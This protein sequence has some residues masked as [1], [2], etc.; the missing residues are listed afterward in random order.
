MEPIFRTTGTLDWITIL[1]FSSLLFIIIA[2]SLF[3]TRFL[4]YIILP[5][6]NKYIYMYNKKEK[7]MNW[8]NVFF[9]LFQIINFSLFIFFAWSIISQPHPDHQIFGYFV[10]LGT[11]I[12]FQIIKFIF[13]IGNGFIFSN[14]KTFSELVFKKISYLN[15]S[16]ILMFIAN[17][18]LCY[19]LKESKTVVYITVIL[20]L[21]ING[22]GWVTVLKNHQKFITN[23]FF[24]F[25]LY[26][27][28]L[29]IA[30]FVIMGS[31]L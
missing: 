9:T 24:Y 12:L 5:F 1:L 29:E 7:L 14:I 13:Q 28:A 2:K 31:L 25:I 18:I 26:L 6:N 19:I 16:A 10:I 8:F 30:P 17:I 3:Y 15:Y 4:N 11:V 20:I 27:C 22:I 21:I 23:N